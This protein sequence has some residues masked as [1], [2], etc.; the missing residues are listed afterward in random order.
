MSKVSCRVGNSDS[1]FHC[2]SLLLHNPDSSSVVAHY[3]P[4][5]VLLSSETYLALI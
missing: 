5:I 4:W 2:F 3:D 1:K